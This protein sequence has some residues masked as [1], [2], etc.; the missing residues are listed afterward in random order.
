MPKARG[1]GRGLAALIPD[2]PD[3]AEE[4]REL[5][6]DHVRPNPF[7]PRQHFD[8]ALLAE[9]AE[10]IRQH[11]VLQPVLVRRRGGEYE[12]VAGERRVRAARAAGLTA[13]PALV[14]DWD[15]RTVME[16]ALVENLQRRDLNPMEEAEAF[17]RLIE[18]F[19]WTQEQAADRVGKSRSHVANY[20]RLLQLNP[21]VRDL[22]AQGRLSMAHAKVLL[23]VD[24]ERRAGMAEKAAAEEWTVRQLGAAA[25]RR[26]PVEPPP[27]DVHMRAV[28]ARLGRI[29]GARVTLRGTPQRGRIVIRYG[30]LDELEQLLDELEHS[31]DAPP[32]TRP[33]SV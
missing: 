15:D 20:L 9:L 30:S 8:D 22:V 21:E 3:A 14:R 1:L 23:S 33:F 26:E 2:Q 32:T 27:P 19:G 7:Q 11:G 25:V 6:L 18:E 24:P 16:V 28:E 13:V 5:P 4:P 17:R 31:Q 12:L 29:L 10:S